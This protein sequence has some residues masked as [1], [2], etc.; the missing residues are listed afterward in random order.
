MTSCLWNFSDFYAKRKWPSDLY[1]LSL[2]FTY[3]GICPYCQTHP[4]GLPWVW[5][6]FSYGIT[7]TM[8]TITTPPKSNI[9]RVTRHLI[10]SMQPTF[11][12]TRRFMQRKMCVVCS[13]CVCVLCVC[14]VCVV[15]FVLCVCCVN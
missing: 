4:N 15:L 12:L 9:S 8:T 13:C 1:F 3:Q 6:L 14:F 7:M 10:F 5:T 11:N 2:Y